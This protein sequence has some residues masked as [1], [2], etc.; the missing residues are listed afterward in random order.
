[1]KYETRN[2]QELPKFRD[3]LSYLYLEHGRLEQQDQ[4]VAFYTQ[5]GVI[6][7]PAAALGVLLLGPGTAVTHAAIRQLANNGCSVFWVGEEMVRFY[8][9]GMGETR[10]SI[11]LMRQVQAWA[12][13]QAHLEVVK[14]MYRMRFPE[15]LPPDLSLEQIRGR[16]G[17]RVRETYARWSR[18]TG[19]PWKGRNYNRGNWAEADPINRALSAGAAC[20]YG[21]C[22]AAIVSA[23][24]SPALGFIHTG[25]QLSFVY[26]IAD[27]Y[28]AETLIPTA[29][30]VVAESEQGVERRVRYTLRDQLKRVRLLER[31]VDD[32]HRLFNGLEIPDPYAADPAAPGELW[33]PEGNLP[34]GVAYGLDGEDET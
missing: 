21:L 28:K 34:G 12:D 23:G 24:Y 3:G 6:S 10:S 31:V 5:E 15:G 20:L 1:M 9:S 22:H 29:F 7:I 25:K 17:V 19:V 33:D 27:L 11:H 16:E 26:D 32:L 18:E 30:Q 13:P 2:L 8:A 14:R 4:A